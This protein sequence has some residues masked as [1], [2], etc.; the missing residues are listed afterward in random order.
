MFEENEFIELKSKYNEHVTK[1]IVAFLNTEGGIIYL[2]VEDNGN[3]VGVKKLEETLKNISDT[4]T[5]SILPNPQDLISVYTK[6]ISNKIIIEINIKK[7]NELYYIKKY[8]RSNKGCYIRVGS[9]CRSMTEEQIINRFQNYYVPMFDI[10]K[11]ESNRDDLTFKVLKIYYS[12]KNYHL[13]N[14]TFLKNLNLLTRNNK[15][16]LLAELLADSNRISIKLARFKGNDKSELIEKSEYGY[17]CLLV[18][19][20]RMINRLEAENYTMSLIHGAKR[21]DKRLIDMD[22]LREVFINAIAHNDWTKFEPVVYIFDDR[23]EIFSYG[24]LPKNQT[25]DMFFKGVSSPRNKALMRILSDLDYVEQTGH[26]I[27][28]VVKK[29][30]KK[31]FD[32]QKNYI[33]VMLPFDEEMIISAKQKDNIYMQIEDSTQKEEDTTRKTE[34]TTRKT[35][36]TTRKEEDTTRKTEE[37]TT[38]KEENTTRKEEDTTRKAEDTTRKTEDVSIQKTIIELILINPQ[39]TKKEIARIIK[40]SE[41][42]VK[43][44][45]KVLSKKGIVERKGST[46][47]GY[48]IIKKN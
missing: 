39:I 2:G 24:G 48:Y 23:I 32:I 40:I 26:G 47:K 43:Y 11:I 29:Y 19:I 16:N 15:Y 33:N 4:I 20:D 44:H 7:G 18:S 25:I 34:D 10:T 21:I 3:V 31:I 30:G 12:G 17:Q 14:R 8:G 42:G 41:N 28:D 37:D 27:P 38:R 46:K 9:T 22:A 45:I 13:S 6:N 35:E 5:T 36:D 1:E